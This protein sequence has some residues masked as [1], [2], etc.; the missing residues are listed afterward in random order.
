MV[1]QGQARASGEPGAVDEAR[2]AADEMLD[3]SEE[4]VEKE[5]ANFRTPRFQRMRFSLDRDTQTIINRARAS[6]D[7]QMT[8][9][10]SDAYWILNEFWDVVREPERDEAGEPRVDSRGLTIW[11]VK[12]NGMYDEDFS[13]LTRAQRE[14]FMF[15]ITARIFAWEQLSAEL[16]GD[17]MFARARFEERFAIGYDEPVSGTVDDRKARGN[18][19]AAEERYYAIFVTTLSRRADALV[20][21]ME[22]LSLRLKDSLA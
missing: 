16:W 3:M 5:E 15:L 20:R 11:A 2:K 1:A 8:R 6:V 12:P 13:K 9:I 7:A 17:A 21:S 14:R 10:F 18:L 19:Q 4:P 22:R